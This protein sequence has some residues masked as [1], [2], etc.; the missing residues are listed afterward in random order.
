MKAFRAVLLASAVVCAGVALPQPAGAATNQGPGGLPPL[1]GPS[2][3][4]SSLK[5]CLAECRGQ[6]PASY[7]KCHTNC[8][9]LSQGCYGHPAYTRVKHTPTPAPKPT[10]QPT[11]EPTS[12]HRH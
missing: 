1:N 2:R 4:T 12:K 9:L 7:T 10:P 3:C 8:I 6:D 11:P 5:I